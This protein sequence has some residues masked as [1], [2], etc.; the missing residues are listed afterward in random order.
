[1]TVWPAIV[2]GLEVNDSRVLV[3]D[4]RFVLPLKAGMSLFIAWG[5]KRNGGT[6][7]KCCDTGGPPQ[8][9]VLA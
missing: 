6:L 1:M 9:G 8:A 5:Y 3:W 4:L 2:C 7:L